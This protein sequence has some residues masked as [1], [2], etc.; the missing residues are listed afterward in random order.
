[1]QLRPRDPIAALAPGK[2][3]VARSGRAELTNTILTE[4]AIRD[5]V[6]RMLRPSGRR[7]DLSNPA[8]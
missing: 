4:V 3:F 5:L 8:I 2:V 6:E 7:L 1:M